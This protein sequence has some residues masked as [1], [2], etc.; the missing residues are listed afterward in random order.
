M[1][2]QIVM[3]IGALKI[4]NSADILDVRKK[5]F[6]IDDTVLSDLKRA[7]KEVWSQMLVASD[8]PL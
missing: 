6:I 2:I 7:V 1:K 4:K 5:M 3:D 8:V